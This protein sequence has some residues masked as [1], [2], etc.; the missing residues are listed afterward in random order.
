MNKLT[1]TL[2]TI[3]PVGAFLFPAVALG[4]DLTGG[5][6][7]D[8]FGLT[9]N[10]QNLVNSLIPLIAALALL[11]FFWGLAKYVFQADDEEAKEKGKNIMIA[12]I[13]ALFLIA[14]VG[15]IIEFLASAFGFDTGD[16]VPTTGAGGTDGSGS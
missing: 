9:T 13:V 3:L 15:G 2:L 4:Q 14:A 16:T 12:G 1:K 8:F 7:G 5:E 6:S 10:I 11:A